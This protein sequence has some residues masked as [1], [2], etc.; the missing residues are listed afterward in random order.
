MNQSD[1]DKG[2]KKKSTLLLG[3]LNAA[4]K[5]KTFKDQVFTL[6]QRV[7]TSMQ[8]VMCISESTNKEALAKLDKEFPDLIKDTNLLVEQVKKLPT[9]K[10]ISYK[11]RYE[12]AKQKVPL[13]L[14]LVADFDKIAEEKNKKFFFD[15]EKA[16]DNTHIINAY[17]HEAT[18]FK[19]GVLYKLYLHDVFCREAVEMSIALREDDLPDRFKYLEEE[20]SLRKAQ[21][22]ELG[23]QA[24]D[25]MLNDLNSD[26]KKRF[27]ASYEKLK[28]IY[29]GLNESKP[30]NLEDIPDEITFP[31]I[32][33][34]SEI[35][36]NQSDTD[37]LSQQSGREYINFTGNE[38]TILQFLIPE[39]K[40][41]S[42]SIPAIGG[43][44]LDTLMQA[45]LSKQISINQTKESKLRKRTAADK[46]LLK[47][48]A[49]INDALRAI[50][51]DKMGEMFDPHQ[52][53]LSWKADP[54]NFV[55][56]ITKEHEK[57]QKELII[58]E[59]CHLSGTEL[60]EK[61]FAKM[62]E[63]LI[64]CLASAEKALHEEYKKRKDK[65][66][67]FKKE[68]KLSYEKELKET[69]QKYQQAITEMQH[70]QKIVEE[71]GAEQ[72][73]I[74]AAAADGKASYSVPKNFLINA[75]TANATLSVSI[76]PSAAP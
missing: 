14:C 70:F 4:H 75:N 43:F 42:V 62:H 10:I 66:L 20:G 72:I 57:Y 38:L 49:I 52:G 46:F 65:S 13:R 60:T 18:L 29:L 17:P 3:D 7:Q 6:S 22:I 44:A 63:T 73:K 61:F 39:H 58:T 45:C 2:T 25:E 26:T 48:S 16:L 67:F 59:D 1:D 54:D 33:V 69:K 40:K 76:I 5:K 50:Q 47:S 51:S 9:I 12:T 21:Y 23:K 71:V 64:H 37:S 32:P 19:V 35:A 53:Y 8:P 41:N 27:E 55:K 68:E 28:K 31:E 74:S 56:E 15:F 11:A 36:R 34:A 30:D 24:Y